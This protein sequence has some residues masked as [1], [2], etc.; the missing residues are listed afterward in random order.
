MELKFVSCGFSTF[1]VKA[2]VL[3]YEF[4]NWSSWNVRNGPSTRF[5]IPHINPQETKLLFSNRDLF[6]LPLVLP[7]LSIFVFSY[8]FSI[9]NTW[10]LI[11]LK[12]LFIRPSNHQH[13]SWNRF[14][15]C[16][17]I[18]KVSSICWCGIGYSFLGNIP[19]LI[20]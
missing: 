4:V 15:T 18:F 3:F 9:S 8:F 5:G 11:P 12:Q 1:R 13:S 6:P 2:S 20:R 7:K 16:L 10:I 19:E 14:Q 17:I